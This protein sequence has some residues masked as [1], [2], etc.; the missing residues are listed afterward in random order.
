MNHSNQ[1]PSVAFFAGPRTHRE[2]KNA[3]QG[4]LGHGRQGKL[5]RRGV[6]G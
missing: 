5:G 2:I 3:P 1:K 6:L 4:K